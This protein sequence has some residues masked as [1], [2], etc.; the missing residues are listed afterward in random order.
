MT[1]SGLNMA[2]LAVTLVGWI[3]IAFVLLKLDR[4]VK[5]LEE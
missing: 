5:K 4:R 3:G 1:T 2:V